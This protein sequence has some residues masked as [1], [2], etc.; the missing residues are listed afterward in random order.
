MSFEERTGE[1]NKI[2]TPATEAYGVRGDI[3]IGKEKHL[4]TQN[5]I[6]TG[7]F[8]AR[9][10]GTVLSNSE[11]SA[12]NV[13]VNGFYINTDSNFTPTSVPYGYICNIVE[14][15]EPFPDPPNPNDST[16]KDC[17]SAYVP[18]FLFTVDPDQAL[19][20]ANVG[21]LV[22][23]SYTNSNNRTGGRYIGNLEKA[24]GPQFMP[25]SRLAANSGYNPNGYSGVTG[26]AL[27]AAIY[28]DYP[29]EV[30]SK[31][32]GLILDGV[33]YN[34]RIKGTTTDIINFTMAEGPRHTNGIG[35]RASM[36][37]SMGAKNSDLTGIVIHENAGGIGALSVADYVAKQNASSK[38]G[39][40]IV[41]GWQKGKIQCYQLSDPVRD[42]VWHGTGPSPKTVGLCVTGPS[43]Y[44]ESLCKSP[45]TQLKWPHQTAVPTTSPTKASSLWWGPRTYGPKEGN[46]GICKQPE[47]IITAM[48]DLISF[49]VD[50]VPT[51]PFAFPTRE[52]G[53][54]GPKRIEK[55]I[56]I[57]PG[58]ISHYCY[59]S[60]RTDGRYLLER[61]IAKN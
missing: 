27:K 15:K 44:K 58:I 42:L 23:V 30:D 60:N 1:F 12:T 47:S 35:R 55:T 25:G 34:Y 48:E 59:E 49:I 43:T 6:G 11:L 53:P 33:R 16:Y 5:S 26:A 20:P 31:G 19:E 38:T 7:A 36:C 4:I 3:N 56:N 51:I 52:L 45:W 61:L 21:D 41:L 10:I 46:R 2:R 39:Y 14:W 9:V 8:E 28:S 29:A 18:N 24:R 22:L 17:L 40:H 32:P 13:T 50:K 57:K 37:K 54:D